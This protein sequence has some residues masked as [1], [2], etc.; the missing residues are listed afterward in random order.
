MFAA[1]NP[2]DDYKTSV[3]SGLSPS[4]IMEIAGRGM[5]FWTYQ[6][7]QE[8]FVFSLFISPLS[9]THTLYV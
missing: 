6:V 8:V 1:L 3:L 5:A 9:L 7:T 4:V 2:T